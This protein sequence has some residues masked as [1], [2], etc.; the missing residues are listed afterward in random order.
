MFIES[1]L[2]QNYLEI[3]MCYFVVIN[4]LS[5]STRTN[6]NNTRCCPSVKIGSGR[7][8]CV[9]LFRGSGQPHNCFI[10]EAIIQRIRSVDVQ[11]T[12]RNENCVRYAID[13]DIA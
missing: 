7:V 10:R 3:E 6:L 1:L 4:Q 13:H 2:A 8:R 9:H 12:A 5:V 11:H